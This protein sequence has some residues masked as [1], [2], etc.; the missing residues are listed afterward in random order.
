MTEALRTYLLSVVAACLL[1]ASLM[2]LVPKGA[3]H[4]TLSFLCGLIV[5]LAAIGPVAKINFSRMSQELSRVQIESDEASSG[6]EIDNR[7]LISAIIK[8]KAEAY[9]LDKAKGLGFHPTVQVEMEDGE[10]Y[11]YPA[12]VSLKGACTEQQKMELSEIIE[13]D[14]AIPKA[15]QEWSSG[16]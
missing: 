11:P 13:Q 8:E 1:S 7:D 15:S 2:A 9:I 16:E 12:G 3:V 6:I 5:I 14:L 4:R 10:D